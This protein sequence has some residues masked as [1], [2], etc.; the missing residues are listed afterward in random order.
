MSFQAS[1]TARRKRLLGCFCALVTTA[2]V[3]FAQS[4]RALEDQ[5][6]SGS[7]PTASRAAPEVNNDEP[8]PSGDDDAPVEQTAEARKDE[9]RD[10]LDEVD[11]SIQGPE[12]IPYDQIL[13]VQWRFIRKEGAHE[14]EPIFFGAQPADSFR[15]Q[16][17]WGFSYTYNVL[18]DFAIEA[19]H[20]SFYKNYATGLPDVIR[21]EFDRYIDRREP[22]FSLGSA[23][24]WAPLKSKAATDDSIHYFEGYFLGGGGFTRLENKYVGTASV[25]AGFR[26]YLSQ[27]SIFKVELR[28]QMDFRSG[29]PDHR[30]NITVGAALLM[31]GDKK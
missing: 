27:R 4:D 2:D 1:T 6:L 17:T 3:A 18:E 20:A 5:L 21:S 13:V 16:I 14:I 9:V 19:I 25:G 8:V 23:L 22:V 31:G 7:A 11:Q 10:E 29:S 26:A 12:D 15:R 30:F 28:D 24:I